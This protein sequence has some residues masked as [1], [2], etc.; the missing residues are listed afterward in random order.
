MP[1]I[2]AYD[3]ETYQNNL[4]VICDAYGNYY[5]PSGSPDSLLDWLF[6]T[7]CD[8]NFLY[9]L[10]FDTAIIFRSIM[11]EVDSEDNGKYHY[12]NYDI[13]Y[14]SNKS[15]IIKRHD[16]KTRTKIL[17]IY[18]IAQFYKNEKGY[19][20]L[21]KVSKEVLGIGK[22]QE[23]L[24]IKREN[25]GQIEGYYEQHRDKII[26]YCINDCY[27][28]LQLAKRKIESIIPVLNG[29]IP[30][31]YN[32]SA[33]ISKA[34]LSVYHSDLRYSYYTLIS[35]LDDYKE[36]VKII[37]NSYFG[38]IFYLHS[39]GK[40]CNAYEYDINSAYPYAITKLFS[41]KDAEIH[42]TDRYEEADYS[43]YHV[44]IR[45]MSDLPI[46]YRTG[47]T[48]ITYIRSNDF[49]ENY[50]T[51][52]E[53]DY[54]AKYHSKDIQFEIIEGVVINTT[55]QK[56]FED[57]NGLYDKRNEIKQRMKDKKQNEKIS[58]VKLGSLEED[59]NQWSY[60]TVLNAS[61]GCFAERRNGYT[62]F[63]N[64]IYAS[65][66]TAITRLRIYQIID[67]VGFKHIKAVM[68]DAVLT[69]V[70]IEDSEFNSNELGNFKLEGKFDVIWLYMNG[71]YVS[72][73]GNRISLHNR[74]FPSLTDIHSLFNAK[75]TRLRIVRD[76]KF[77][78]IK[79]GIIQHRQE[80]IGKFTT[81]TK[82]L[83]L[84]ANRWKYTLDVSKLTFEYLKDNELETDYSFNVELQYE[85]MFKPYQKRIDFKFFNDVMYHSQVWK[86]KPIE[87]YQIT[88]I[89]YETEL[90]KIQ[91]GKNTKRDLKRFFMR[92]RNLLDT[93]FALVDNNSEKHR[94]MVNE[95]EKDSIIQITDNL[96]FFMTSV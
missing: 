59:M 30:K 42:Y 29:Q 45:N 56:E 73:V 37:E 51:G 23:E 5:E 17:R 53:L 25:I 3:T 77:Y 16:S 67:R 1:S 84:E 94:L 69:D 74:G 43:F 70:E 7:A 86:V 21:D 50:F 19:Q 48:D 10:D 79:E 52:I 46:H 26:E 14:I 89:D 33:S 82:Y 15:L 71:I 41:L 40:I 34:Y 31:T 58:G 28:T 44:K 47:E 80:D 95:I 66:I 81:Q 12:K 83:N 2:N 87:K 39:L 55:K 76:K 13:Y 72:Q 57:F 22:N 36:A 75:G 85:Y 88:S 9:N 63:T 60:K 18:D 32:S 93:S 92:Y 96:I 62:V 11:P 24:E 61:Y 78:K 8:L 38:G 65:Y 35:K 68:T 90:N 64:M 49:V 54:F 91:N 20:S 6:S 4:K 27:L